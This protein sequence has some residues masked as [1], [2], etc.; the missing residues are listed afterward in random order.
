M[1]RNKKPRFPEGWDGAVLVRLT[2]RAV[3]P[4]LPLFAAA[5]AVLHKTASLTSDNA[6]VKLHK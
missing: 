5:G 3:K 1:P 6:C 4:A 2:R